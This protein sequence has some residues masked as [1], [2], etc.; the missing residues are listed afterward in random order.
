MRL[1]IGPIQRHDAIRAKELNEFTMRSHGRSF[2]RGSGSPSIVIFRAIM[3]VMDLRPEL[4]PA[5]VTEQRLEALSLTELIFY[6]P[7]DLKDASPEQIADAALSH[8]PIAL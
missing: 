3:P 2:H 5:L 7:A 1:D 6:P 4:L 8:R